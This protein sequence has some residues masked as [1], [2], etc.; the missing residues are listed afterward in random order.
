MDAAILHEKFDY[1]DGNLYRKTTGKKAGTIDSKGYSAI[2]VN[3]KI[4]RG[5]R[6]I[7]L[8]HHGYLPEI[9]DHIDGNRLNN[10]I[11]NLR[12]ATQTE[13]LQNAKKRTNNVS[14]IKNVHW[15]NQKQKWVVKLCV[16]GKRIYGGFFENLDDAKQVALEQRN[17]Y[18]GSYANNG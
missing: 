9:I 14:G 1:C 4:Y 13:N 2:T 3:R 7:F 10:R 8:Y 16:K 5:H 17:L 12:E 11:E 6:L 15:C 18:Y